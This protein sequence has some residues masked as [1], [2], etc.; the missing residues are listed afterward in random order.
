MRGSSALRGAAPWDARAPERVRL[1]HHARRAVRVDQTL[2]LDR[3]A[4]RP[5]GLLEVFQRV[6]QALVRVAD[7][8]L[9]LVDADVAAPEQRGADDGRAAAVERVEYDVAGVA[10]GLD[11]AIEDGD[12]HLAAVPPLALLEGA[13]DAAD[14]PRVAVG[15]EQRLGRLLRAQVPGVVGHLPAGAGALVVVSRL[16]RACDLHRVAVERDRGR[17]GALRE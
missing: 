11:D 17:V 1:G 4:V 5:A 10:R 9:G 2:Q 16:P 3:R 6:R 7:V 15:R 14:V 12:G 8:L 13:A